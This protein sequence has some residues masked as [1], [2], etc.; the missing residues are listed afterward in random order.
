MIAETLHKLPN[1]VEG[2]PAHWYERAITAIAAKAEAREMI[3]RHEK[4]KRGN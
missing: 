4:S 1:E 3:E 2:M